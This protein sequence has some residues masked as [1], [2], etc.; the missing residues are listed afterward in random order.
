M[1]A[2]GRRWRPGCA[3]G[4][5]VFYLGHFRLW[6]TSFFNFGQFYFGQ[7]LLRP[8]STS[9]NLILGWG[10]QRRG[11]AEG[12]G[13]LEGGDTSAQNVSTTKGEKQ[14]ATR[15][16]RTCLQQR[17]RNNRRHVRTESVDDQWGAQRSG[18][19]PGKRAA[20]SQNDPRE[21][22]THTLRGPWP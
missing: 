22:Q 14:Q 4:Q 9:A 12:G 6:S 18:A 11:G 21:A 15:P 1:R 8:S 10:A 13:G 16:H 5:G 2:V 17:E 7:V 19:K 20:V 3:K